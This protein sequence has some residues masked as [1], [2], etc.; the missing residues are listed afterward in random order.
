MFILAFSLDWFTTIPGILIS[1]GVVLL[2]VAIILFATGS[3]KD[4]NTNVVNN[5]QTEANS[6]V[7]GENVVTPVEPV[8]T[9][10]TQP[11]VENV[12]V[13]TQPFMGAVQTEEQPKFEDIPMGTP[14]VDPINPVDNSVVPEVNNEVVEVPAAFSVEEPVSMSITPEVSVYGGTNP[15]DNIQTVSVEEDKKPTIYGGNDPLE[16]TQSLPKVEEHH[17]PYGGAINDVKIVEPVVEDVVN[18]PEVESEPIQIETPAV[19]AAPISFEVPSAPIEIPSEPVEVTSEPIETKVDIPEVMVEPT[20]QP[21][22][23]PVVQN[24]TSEKP[25]IEE[26]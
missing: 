13:E 8:A 20:I 14:G 3:K 16:A 15:T 23:E 18:V 7:Q 2:I 25:V 19:E 10:Q 9:V 11:V 6:N 4:K 17:E 21:V 12:Q 5:I 1:V 24:T 26:L 22:V